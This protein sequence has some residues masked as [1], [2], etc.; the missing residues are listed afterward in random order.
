MSTNLSA[1]SAD[2]VEQV[3]NEAAHYKKEVVVDL[4]VTSVLVRANVEEFSGLR[5]FSRMRAPGESGAEA[6]YELTCV[7]LDHPHSLDEEFVWAH[8]DRSFRGKRFRG[9]FYLTYHFG[10]PAA[11]ISRGSRHYVVGR[12]LDRIIWGWY[13]KYILT[14]NSLRE[15]TLHLKAACFSRD[16]EGTLLIGRGGGG[17]TVLLTQ[18]C[19]DGAAFVTNTHVV[20]DRQGVARGVPTTLRVRED[21]CFGGLIRSGQ[22]RAHLDDDEFI[23]D[24]SALFPLSVPGAR[25]RNI[26]VV[27][28]SPGA[29]RVEAL[30]TDS[31]YDLF[32]QFGFP[33]NTYG[34]KD[35]VLEHFGGDIHGFAAGY[36]GMK[37]Q[38]REMVEGASCFY[39]SC[40]MMNPEARARLREA[41]RA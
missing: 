5:Y 41:L 23:A 12:K 4:G 7:D 9:G 6:P 20:V 37:G 27:D 38:L 13:V 19:Q 1:P 22:L 31:A 14:V 21:P 18:F 2:A 39:V 11:L 25:V 28:Y 40:D 29:A 35:D 24:P 8:A 16:G 30:D 34:M 17:K 33:I 10:A 15:G 3:F 26:C 36:A 32:E